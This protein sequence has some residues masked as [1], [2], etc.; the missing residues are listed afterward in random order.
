MQKHPQN[1]SEDIRG[2]NSEDYKKAEVNNCQIDQYPHEQ[3]IEISKELYFQ[4]LLTSTGGNL[5]VRSKE[6]GTIWITPSQI[7]KGKLDQNVMVCIDLDGNKVDNTAL[8]PSS[9]KFIHTEIYKTFEDIQAVIHAHAPYSTI[10]V[11]SGLPFL[12]LCIEAAFI[13]E[14]PRI[15]FIMPGTLELAKAVVEAMNPHKIHTEKSI[16]NPA[17]LLQNHGIVVAATNLRIAADILEIIERTS[18]LI[19]TCY[20]IGIK[21]TVIPDEVILQIRNAGHWRA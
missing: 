21:P 16:W 4:G 8:Q 15:P 13:E 11:L 9:E 18:L 20:S 2:K 5:S 1:C 7:H 10:L 14:L 17:V 12:P 6:H 19:V 3:I